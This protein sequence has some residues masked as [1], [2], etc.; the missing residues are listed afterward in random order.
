LSGSRFSYLAG[1]VGSND[2]AESLVESV[3]W[4][5]LAK[6]PLVPSLNISLELSLKEI[7]ADFWDKIGY[8][9][10]ASRSWKR[11][12]SAASPEVRFSPLSSRDVERARSC[13]TARLSE[14][15]KGG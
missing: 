2:D 10:S 7:V 11:A 9:S 8:P 15:G 3:A 1:E 13:S 12:S 6:E 5:G 4:Q 14:S